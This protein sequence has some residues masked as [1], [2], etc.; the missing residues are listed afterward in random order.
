MYIGQGQHGVKKPKVWTPGVAGPAMYS[1]SPTCVQYSGVKTGRRVRS[2]L[3][4]PCY[5]KVPTLHRAPASA[6]CTVP[7]AHS[8][9]TSSMFIPLRP[10]PEQAMPMQ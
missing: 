3:Q 2:S 4:H 7:P 1:T 8:P 9:H 5:E 10:G 6:H